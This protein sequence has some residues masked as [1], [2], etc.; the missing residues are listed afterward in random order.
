MKT[1]HCSTLMAI[2]PR[3]DLV[4]ARG[5]GSY[6]WDERGTRYLDFVQGWAVNALGHCAP[7]VQAALAEQAAR[8]ITPSPAYH[9][10][11]QL[12]LAAQLVETS[13]LA[14]AHFC[15]TGA[16]AN[17]AAVKLARKWGRTRRR[18]AYEVITTNNA[19]HGRTFAMMA[20]SGK[21]GWDGLFPPNM[22][23][24]RRVAYGDPA[25]VRA[26]IGD[27]TVAIMVEPIQGEGG[28]IVPARGYLRELRAIADEYGV[29]LIADEIQTGIGR[30]G[31]LFCHQQEQVL[32]DIL[33][34]GKGLGAGVPIAAVL[35]NQIASCFDYGDQGGTYNGN[36]LVTAVALKVLQIVKEP[37]F[38]EHVR[39]TGAYLRERLRTLEEFGCSARGSG[40]LW[41]IVLPDDC[42][43][44]V[45]DECLAAGVLVNAP[46]PNLIRLMPSL[47]VQHS[48]VDELLAVLEPILRQRLL[49]VA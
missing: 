4:I 38:L 33:T 20:A 49:R 31:T 26:V 10:R 40:L 2:T 37:A 46:R 44:A 42:A 23:G 15:S 48:E 34:L 5:A 12:E 39:S 36:P 3:P 1:N 14:Q 13:G 35:A 9:N 6:V 22:P 45:R 18:A 27:H 11:P 41:A 43:E 21:L 30:T 28:V 8:L 29:L 19:F 24:F 7:E 32:P 16:E 17:E 25:A 47:R